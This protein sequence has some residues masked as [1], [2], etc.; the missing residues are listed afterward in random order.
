MRVEGCTLGIRVQGPG[1]TAGVW[2][3]KT[4]SYRK[5][6]GWTRGEKQIPNDTPFGRSG[7]GS[8]GRGKGQE[9]RSLAA[10]RPRARDLIPVSIRDEYDSSLWYWS[11]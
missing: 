2:S 6:E 7:F 10:P 11:R 3:L 8:F 9:H 5:D 1:L 4:Q